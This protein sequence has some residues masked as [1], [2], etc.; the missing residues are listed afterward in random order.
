MVMRTGQE[1]KGE[2]STDLKIQK[3]K[4]L[5]GGRDRKVRF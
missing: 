2:M 5:R 3:L 1:K 4:Y